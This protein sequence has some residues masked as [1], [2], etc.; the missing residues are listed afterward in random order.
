MTEQNGGLSS[1]FCAQLK[2]QILTAAIKSDH[3]G[4]KQGATKS[5]DG[6]WPQ[7]LLTANV[8]ATYGPAPNQ[9]TKV[10]DENFN[11]G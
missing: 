1:T 3:L 4:S 5:A 8:H 10:A 2:E 6:R 7:N 11:F 9:G